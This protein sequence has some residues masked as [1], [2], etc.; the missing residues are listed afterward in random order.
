[1]I[2]RYNQFVSGVK[3]NEEFIMPTKSDNYSDDMKPEMNQMPKMEEEEVAVD[4][5]TLALQELSDLANEMGLIVEYSPV[6]SA[7]IDAPG[8]G[9]STGTAVVTTGGSGSGLLLNI[10]AVGGIVTAITIDTAGSGYVVGDIVTVSGGGGDCDVEIT[11]IDENKFLTI[12]GKQVIFPTE[13]E[14]YHIDGVKK[15]FKT[16]QEVVDYFTKEIKAQEQ[17]QD[18]PEMTNQPVE[19]EFESKSYKSKRY[20]R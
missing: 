14:R 16:S 8:T 20:K 2:K 4:R 9:Y 19:M 13:T 15:S 17:S 11:G 7:I 6:T 3:T 18:L 5:Y 12:E 10:T 1:M